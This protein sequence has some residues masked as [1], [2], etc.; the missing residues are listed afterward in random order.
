MNPAGRHWRAE[1]SLAVIAFIWGATFVVVKQALAGVSTFLFLA[2]RFT[3]ASL[4]LA[5]FLRSRLRRRPRLDWTGGCVCGGFL[6]AGYVLQTSGLRFTTASN[7][8][9][10]TGLNVVLVPLLGALVYQ[11]RIRAVEWLAAALATAGTAFMSGGGLRLDWNR[12][13]LM[14][15]G[16]AAA[17]AAH[18]LA[19]ERY[20][21]RMDFERLSLFQVAAVALLA[22]VGT[23]TLETPRIVWSARL[24]FALLTTSVLATAVS[25]LLYTWAQR[26]TTAARAALIFALEPVFAGGMAWAVAGERWTLC[27]LGGAA[28]ILAAIVLA[29]MKPAAAAQHQHG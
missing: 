12:G 11:G 19:M 17:F 25:F 7:S 27:S 5:F 26:E 15:A 4:L 1:A 9:F 21:R 24:W 18:I 6:F 14:T 16:C 10:I 22:W 3:L 20:S 29:E 2:L 8:A 28:L 23:F 13:D